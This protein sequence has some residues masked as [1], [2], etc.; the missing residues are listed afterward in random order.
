LATQSETTLKV[1]KK[2]EIFTSAD[3][4]KRANIKEGGKVKASIVGDK[5]IIEAIP[6]IEEILRQPAVIRTTTKEIE[7]LS[8]KIQKE[9]G[10]YG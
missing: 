1:G 5:L 7:K 9:E 10:I 2:G 4:R 6:S 8:E 3:L